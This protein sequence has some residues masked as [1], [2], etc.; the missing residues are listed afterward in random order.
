MVS[1]AQDGSSRVSR[2]LAHAPALVVLAASIWLL[3][4]AGAKFSHPGFVRSA[5][6]A[7][8]VLSAPVPLW[9]AFAIAAGELGGASAA[10]LLVMSNRVRLG[11]AAIGSIFLVLAL[12]TGWV[13]LHPPAKPA[14]CGCGGSSKPVADWGVIAGRNA[15]M[16]G[17]LIVSGLFGRGV[18]GGALRRAPTIDGACPEGPVPSV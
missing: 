12:Y 11:S 4:A 9:I 14:P 17:I 1:Q 10:I 5:I 3:F 18:P 15:A 2:W 7:Q 6:E 13:W 8:G 16:L